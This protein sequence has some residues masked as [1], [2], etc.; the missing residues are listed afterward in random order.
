MQGEQQTMHDCIIGRGGGLSHLR[1]RSSV[2]TINYPGR[3]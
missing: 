2:Q 1:L 3:W